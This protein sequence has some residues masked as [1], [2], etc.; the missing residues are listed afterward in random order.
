MLQNYI[1]LTFF[2]IITDKCTLFDG[3]FILDCAAGCGVR[4]NKVREWLSSSCRRLGD[5][6]APC[7]GSNTTLPLLNRV[8]DSGG[9]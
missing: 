2:L 7:D 9:R 6:M 8:V 3:C 4:N 5:M 1:F